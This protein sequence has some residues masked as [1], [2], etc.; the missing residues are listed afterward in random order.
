MHIDARAEV[1]VDS[2]ER[3]LE[4]TLRRRVGLSARAEGCRRRPV[5][6]LRPHSLLENPQSG[7]DPAYTRT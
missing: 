3:T 7:R 1:V 6:Q 5:P 4:I 2:R